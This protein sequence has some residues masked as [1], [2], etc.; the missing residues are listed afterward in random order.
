MKFDASKEPKEGGYGVF[1][2]FDVPT[3]KVPFKL[4]RD[5]R[6]KDKA[7]RLYGIYFEEAENWRGTAPKKVRRIPQTEIAKRLGCSVYTVSRLTR[8]L[9]DTGWATV[10]RTGRSNIIIL[11]G[12]PKRRG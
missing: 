9:H 5:S 4:L 11:H 6:V 2:D 10:K 12:R 1:K 7:V 8:E 3:A